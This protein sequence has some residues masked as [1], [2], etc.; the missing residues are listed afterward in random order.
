MKRILKPL[1][2]ENELEEAI[3]TFRDHKETVEKEAELCHMIE[4]KEARAIILANKELQ[5][6]EQKGKSRSKAF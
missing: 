1:E 2:L 5:E 6:I 4:A 3:Q